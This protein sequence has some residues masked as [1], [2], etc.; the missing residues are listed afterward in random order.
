MNCYL[1]LNGLFL[2][3]LL[4]LSSFKTQ[5]SLLGSTGKKSPVVCEMN[6][7]GMGAI[8]RWRCGR[9]V[10]LFCW[11]GR[12][13]KREGDRKRERAI[14]PANAQKISQWRTDF[15]HSCHNAAGAVFFFFWLNHWGV[16]NGFY[17]KPSVWEQLSLVPRVSVSALLKPGN[18]KHAPVLTWSSW[19][20][21]LAES[22]EHMLSITERVGLPQ[23]THRLR[24]FPRCLGCD[25]G[26]SF[27]QS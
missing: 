19:E 2:L 18:A 24:G 17:R 1:Y 27:G 22:T 21:M 7:E 13:S 10:S 12:E 5:T 9:S 11:G 3:F 25:R 26:N 20:L 8:N 14:E 6:K 15:I 23:Q 4:P 16:Y